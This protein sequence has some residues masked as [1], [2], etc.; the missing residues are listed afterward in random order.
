MSHLWYPFTAMQDW[1]KQEQLSI[2]A[3]E[4]NFLVASDGRRYL[5]GVSSLW[6]NVHGHNHPVLNAAI[7]TQVDRI[8][9]STLLGLG[10]PLAEELAERLV[11]VTP[12]GLQHVFYSDSGSTAVEIALKQA[13]Q[14]WQLVGR[15][16]KTGFVH[17]SDAYHGDTLGAVAVGGISI[18]HEIFGPLLLD[19]HA[20]PCP[21]GFHT[22]ESQARAEDISLASIRTLLSESSNSIAAFILEPLVQ[23]AGGILTHS[24]AYLREVASLCR[25]HEVLLILDEVATGFGRTGALFAADIAELKPDFLCLAKGITGG[26]LPLAATLSTSKI[27]EAFLAPR[28]EGKTF[29]HGHTYTGNPLACAAALANLAIFESEQ[30]MMSVPSKAERLSANLREL[31][32]T[33]IGDIRQQGLMV[34]VELREPDGSPLPAQNFS[35]D[36]VC[37]AARDSGVI[38]RNLSDVIVLMPPL[39]IT[40]SEIDLLTESLAH[41]LRSVLQ[42]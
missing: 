13:F 25:A 5:D 4:G 32:Q 40:N 41:G 2:T 23:G 12:E 36:L 11:A 14:Y 39:S 1:S 27:F 34:G 42:A 19:T 6:T 29:F 38:I 31:D 8:S 21:N 35:G 22:G 15:T 26:Y 16:E 30:T 37:R 3:G 10:N 28:R 33:F 9:H 7:K 24:P 18:F 20:V 17:L